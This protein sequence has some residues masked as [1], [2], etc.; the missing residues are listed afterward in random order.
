M[1]VSVRFEFDNTVVALWQM[2]ESV[3]ELALLAGEDNADIAFSTFKGVKRQKEWLATRALLRAIAGDDCR[4][5][6]YDCNKPSLVGGGFISISHTQGYVAVALSAVEPVGLDI[7]LQT[8]DVTAVASRFVHNDDFA[9]FVSPVCN[10]QLLFH[11]CV[12]EAVFKLAGDLGGT[13]KDNI[14]VGP[15]DPSSGVSVANI[16]GLGSYDALFRVHYVVSQGLLVVLCRY[17]VG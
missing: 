3:E 12:K 16:V 15:F 10:A 9:G 1:P 4:V 2:T 14:T 7:E 8:R 6:Y 5:Q 13:F 17:V 11:W